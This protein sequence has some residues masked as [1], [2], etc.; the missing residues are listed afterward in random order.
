MWAPGLLPRPV[1][2]HLLRI[3]KRFIKEKHK[4]GALESSAV[5]LESLF[6]QDNGALEAFSDFLESGVCVAGTLL[7]Q[8][9]QRWN[10]S[11]V[12]LES[13]FPQKNGALESSSDSLDSWGATLERFSRKKTALESLRVSLEF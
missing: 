2:H 8:K 10:P 4:H 1:L 6:P 7:P 5:A 12:A 9:M 11:G 3:C 13:L